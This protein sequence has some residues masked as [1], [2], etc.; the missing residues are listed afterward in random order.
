MAQAKLMHAVDHAAG[1]TLAT[2]IGSDQVPNTKPLMGRPTRLMTPAVFDLAPRARWVAS[3]LNNFEWSAIMKR[4]LIASGLIATFGLA[5]SAAAAFAQPG[6]LG[7]SHSPSVGGASNLLIL[8]RGGGGGHGGGG[9]A[10]GGGGGH[11]GMGDG[12]GHG[13][14]GGHSFRGG[15]FR[16]FGFSGGPFYDDSCWWSP[17]YQRTFC[18]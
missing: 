1:P 11:G 18:E 15:H 16:S 4:K 13:F 17:R 14:G 6:N 3:R 7:G 8:T 10:M 2:Q 9:G 5:L 12:G